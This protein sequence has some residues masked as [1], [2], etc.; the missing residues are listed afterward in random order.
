MREDER[1][2]RGAPDA[3]L[4][5]LTADP[6]I[7]TDRGSA[8]GALLDRPHR[9]SGARSQALDGRLSI[10]DG[11]EAREDGGVERRQAQRV[12]AEQALEHH[13]A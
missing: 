3:Y 5:R 8:R 2:E 10:R 7:V 9:G 6:L 11:G 1:L 4:A 12:D 13:I